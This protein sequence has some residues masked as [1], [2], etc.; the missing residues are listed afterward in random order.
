MKT[1]KLE[2]T[3]EQ[4]FDVAAALL[5]EASFK[6][7]AAK[8]C[9]ECLDRP[10]KPLTPEQIKEFQALPYDLRASAAANRD[11]A[12]KVKA[13]AYAAGDTRYNIK[14]VA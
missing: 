6:E 7:D 3:F 4:A 8:A 10:V 14:R 9:Q 2:L 12:N 1:I 11:L 13:L 5:T